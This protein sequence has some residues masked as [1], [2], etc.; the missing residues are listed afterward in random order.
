MN[1][2]RWIR[3]L[4]CQDQLCWGFMEHVRWRWRK[5]KAELPLTICL[6]PTPHC[7][8][9]RTDA[10]VDNRASFINKWLRSG[11]PQ[12]PSNNWLFN[13]QFTHWGNRAAWGE[14]VQGTI[15][16]QAVS[17]GDTE[18]S[19]LSN[20]FL[21]CSLLP[22]KSY[23]IEIDFHFSFYLLLTKIKECSEVNNTV[24]WSYQTPKIRLCH[25]FSSIVKTI[26]FWKEG[27]KWINDWESRQNNGMR[28]KRERTEG[29]QK[30]APNIW[31]EYSE[32]TPSS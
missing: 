26:W 21:I 12:E 31:M 32:R 13:N 6:S 8:R 19:T 28:A 15:A 4:K 7:L 22:W 3:V 11:R 9:A 16:T 18:S 14:L 20:I 24:R 5:G 1:S 25:C 10:N 30:K 29:D 17:Y 2:R 27:T 23:M